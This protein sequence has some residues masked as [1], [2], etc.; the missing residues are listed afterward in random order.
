MSLLR[1]V[2]SVTV[3][4]T[5]LLAPIHALA[6][7]PTETGDKTGDP[8][9]KTALDS[10]KYKYTVNKSKAYEV[11]FDL[12]DQ[13]SQVVFI[14]SATQK[15]SKLELREVT[16]TA[17]R[18]KGKL[19]SE[20]ALRLLADNDRRTWGSWRLVEEDGFTFVIYAVQ[21]PADSNAD[22][23][24]SAIDAVMYTADEM[25]KEVTKADDF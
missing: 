14:N 4:S 21:L 2:S 23:L 15:F 19:S 24:D 13:R 1:H 20:Q 25:E 9:V 6:Q 8:R 22:T 7:A 17:F 12:K 3:L 18:V 5:I 10:L 16:S 11:T